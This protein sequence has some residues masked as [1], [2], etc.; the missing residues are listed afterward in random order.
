M[1]LID[2]L[3]LVVAPVEQYGEEGG[4]SLPPSG[5]GASHGWSISISITVESVSSWTVSW[6][7]PNLN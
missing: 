2:E 6:S 3:D 5:P 7:Q 4:G 1:A